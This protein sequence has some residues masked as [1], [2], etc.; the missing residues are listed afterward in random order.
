MLQRHRGFTRIAAR[1]RITLADGTIEPSTEP[2]RLGGNRVSKIYGQL[3]CPS[4]NRALARG[5]AKRRVFV[6]RRGDGDRGGISAVRSVHARG[7]SAVE[8]GQGG[9]GVAPERTG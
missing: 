5:Y 3:D 2:G 9:H 8:G 1:Y 7:V 4:A 6:R